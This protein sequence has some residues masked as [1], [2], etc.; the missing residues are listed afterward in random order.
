MAREEKKTLRHKIRVRGLQ[1]SAGG[2]CGRAPCGVAVDGP[3][4]RVGACTELRLRTGWRKRCEKKT[5]NQRS[6]RRHCRETRG[7]ASAGRDWTK[8]LDLD[9]C[10]CLTVTRCQ[11][12]IPGWWSVILRRSHPMVGGKGPA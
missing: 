1:A 2:V 6:S 5:Q 9:V 4:V 12:S 11:M 10:Q 7:E 3:I 8:C